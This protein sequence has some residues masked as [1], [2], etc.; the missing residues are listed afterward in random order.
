MAERWKQ[1]HPNYEVSDQGR[2][3]RT[4][5][6]KGARVGHILKPAPNNKGYLCVH[7]K[8]HGVSL[9]YTV[10][11]LV[12]TAFLGPCPDGYEVGH[13]NGDKT[14]CRASNLVY[15]TRSQNMKHAY[16]VCGR[17]PKVPDHTGSKHGQS[18]LTEAQAV[19]IQKL[20]QAGVSGQTLARLFGVSKAVISTIF[21]GKAW[22]HV[23]KPLTN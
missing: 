15:Q 20:R 19:E 3:R 13:E 7:L 5:G 16:A 10:H 14:D 18:K 1:C 4:V 11:K 12:A 17:V 6:G 8:D 23:T 21:H 22:T 9:P 2:V